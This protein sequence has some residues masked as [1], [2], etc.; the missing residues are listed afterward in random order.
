MLRGEISSL[1]FIYLV[2]K[3]YFCL[4][5]LKDHQLKKTHNRLTPSLMPCHAMIVGFAILMPLKT[6][7]CILSILESLFG[8]YA[9]LYSVCFHTVKTEKTLDGGATV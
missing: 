5:R 2:S 1:L 3:V 4:T 6:G 7:K 8:Q 9:I